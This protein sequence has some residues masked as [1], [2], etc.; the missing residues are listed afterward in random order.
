MVNGRRPGSG[1]R[2]FGTPAKRVCGSG[3][4]AADPAAFNL[5]ADQGAGGGADDGAG[6]A[7]ATGID[8][9]PDQGAAG[10]ADDQAGGAVRALAAPAA[11]A[12][13]PHLAV[14][15]LRV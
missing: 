15:A 12:V 2:G 3:L 7:F 1:G 11:L 4:A 10:C 13:L 6:R 9:T 5:A 14:I 8:G